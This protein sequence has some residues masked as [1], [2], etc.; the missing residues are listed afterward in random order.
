MENIKVLFFSANPATMSL[1]PPVVALFYSIFKKN[2]IE[3]RYFD[4]QAYD[5][6]ALYAD[7]NVFLHSTL[8]AK[9]ENIVNERTAKKSKDGSMIFSDFKAEAKEWQ[10][11]VIMG[12]A[13]ESAFL[14]ARDLFQSVR[15]LNIPHVLGGVFSTF[16]PEVAIGFPEIDIVCNGEGEKIIVP[17]SRKI[18]LK[19]DLCSL[20]NIWFKDSTGNAVKT[21]VGSV[22]SLDE[23]PPFDASIYD[24]DRFYRT[25]GGVMY[26]MF[27][28]ETHRGCPLKCTFCNSPIQDSWYKEKTGQ[29]YFRK[30]SIKNV[31]ADIRYFVKNYNAEY[32]FFWADNFFSY[33][34][35]EIEEFCTEYADIKLPFYVQTYPTTIDDVKLKNL[36]EVGLDRIG[37]GIEHGNEEFRRKV[38]NRVY[39]NKK[40]I[41]GVNLI[42][43]YDVQ[44]SCNNIVGFPTETPELHEETV[45]LNRILEPHDA[46]AAIFTPFHGTPLRKLSLEKG[47]LKDPHFIAP[48]NAETSCLDMPQFTKEQITGKSRTFILYLRF[49]RDRWN[50]IR[51]AESLTPEGN[52]IWME[53]K[54]EYKQMCDQE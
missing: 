54:E 47:Y 10:P 52:K 40:A 13:T 51:H 17:L 4:T 8:M 11:D 1:V 35:Q 32:F 27:P 48:T 29:G 30:K 12:S 19:E 44:Y 21:P 2:N 37:I 23:N 14:F 45:E 53:L 39:S 34:R 5:T 24:D 15:K 41:A 7:P 46:S 18:K 43:K 16:A 31:L 6:S 36:V 33:N 50:D 9:G 3:M 25:M 38:I 20:Q 42:K 49:P 28:V 26:R 22:V